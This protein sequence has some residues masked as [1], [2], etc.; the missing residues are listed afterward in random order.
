MKLLI[1]VER[2]SR[3]SQR[4]G[5]LTTSPCTDQSC[6]FQERKEMLCKRGA[7]PCGL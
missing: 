4:Y 5:Y 2:L 7:I 6:Q 3:D 1:F